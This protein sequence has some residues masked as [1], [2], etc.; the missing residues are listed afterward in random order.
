MSYKR[1]FQEHVHSHWFGVTFFV[2]LIVSVV[3]CMP[4]GW[5]AIFV[6]FAAMMLSFTLVIPAVS[7]K[8][9]E[10][11][12]AVSAEKE[13]LA[14]LAY[15]KASLAQ[16]QQSRNNP[17]YAEVRD[18]KALAATR[19]SMGAKVDVYLPP[20]MQAVPIV[21]GD[22]V[23][24]F[25][26]RRLPETIETRSPAVINKAMPPRLS[27]RPIDP[28]CYLA[29]NCNPSIKEVIGKSAVFLGQRGTGKSM[30]M[31]R[32]IEQINKLP[33]FASLVIDFTGEYASMQDVIEHTIIAGAPDWE[34][35]Y[36]CKG[37]WKLSAE[38]AYAAGYALFE[39]QAF[40]ILQVP[41]YGE[42]WDTVAGV[43]LPLIKGMIAW[44]KG[45]KD[46]NRIPGFIFLDEG[47]FYMPE[48]GN[49]MFSKEN[50][51]EFV[52][53]FRALN[54]FARKWGITPVLA[55]QRPQEI[56]KSA[57]T[58]AELYFL[59]GQKYPLDLDFYEELVGKES[60]KEF[61]LARETFKRLG[62]GDCVVW[63]GD[64][65]WQIHFY[66][67]E[68]THRGKTPDWEDALRHQ[69]K[70]AGA[71]ITPRTIELL[72]KD[73]EIDDEWDQD[74]APTGLREQQGVP[75]V[76]R[77][78]PDTDNLQTFV[79][80]QPVQQLP[81]LSPAPKKTDMERVIELIKREPGLGYREIGERLGFGK[82]KVGSLVREAKERGLLEA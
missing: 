43:I 25:E 77:R 36:Q 18:T 48:K 82:D 23:R 60:L 62:K 6:A 16:Q 55:A 12:A 70:R 22:V 15:R 67:R 8:W 65:C 13:R 46:D 7:G 59:F 30:G 49:S 34:G 5:N 9:A 51:A 73:D 3:L 33:V 54:L 72:G 45:Q 20:V 81:D 61:G 17:A 10:R 41:S 75:L 69:Q 37:Y 52:K 79:S 63:E 38:N 64:D 42:D 44:G 71:Q 50:Q 57:I 76:T 21:D 68:S 56:K 47:T 39:N 19:V 14:E 24:S 1:S 31:G 80:R 29:Q 11:Q 35:Q 26:T 53:V 27:S 78:L 58:G 32:Y 4:L 66:E 40:V 2:S 74:N 28:V